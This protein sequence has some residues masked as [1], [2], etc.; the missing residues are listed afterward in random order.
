[1]DVFVKSFAMF[2]LVLAALKFRLSPL[3]MVSLPVV[4]QAAA[5][6]E[7]EASRERR[8]LHSLFG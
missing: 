7:S 8:T 6:D 5:G 3:V 1:M 2:C 4:F